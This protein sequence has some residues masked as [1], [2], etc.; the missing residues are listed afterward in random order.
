MLQLNVCIL[1][2]NKLLVRQLKDATLQQMICPS[3]QNTFL[4]VARSPAINWGLVKIGN[5]H[6]QFYNVNESRYFTSNSIKPTIK[7]IDFRQK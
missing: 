1:S 7:V 3:G 6:K 4:L 5:F 2:G